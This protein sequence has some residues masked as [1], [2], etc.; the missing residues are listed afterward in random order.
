LL[1]PAVM[2]LDVTMLTAASALAQGVGLAPNLAIW[3]APVWL[4]VFLVHG[5]YDRRTVFAG[6]REYAGVL[7]GCAIA[8]LLLLV[9]VYVDPIVSRAP[10]VATWLLTSLLVSAE[11]FAVRRAVRLLRRRGHLM[12][13]TLI[14]G[15]NEEAIALAEQIVS[16]PGCGS[17]VVGFVDPGV[18]KGTRLVANLEVMGEFRQLDTLI[19]TC[20]V[21]D[22]IVATSAVSRDLLLD[23]YWSYGQDASVDLYLSS[24]VFEILTTPAKIQEINNVPLMTLQRARITELDALLK[25][26]VDY[27]LAATALVI[28][29][30]VLLV[31]A[32]L[33]RLDSPGPVLHRRQVLGVAGKPFYAFKFRTMVADADSVLARDRALRVA[34]ESGHKL[35]RDPRVT[36]VGRILRRTSVDELP[37]LLNVLRGEMSIVGPRMIAPEEAARYGRWQRNLT[38]VKPGITGPWQVAGRSDLSY[39]DRVT[40]NMQYIRNYTFW[41]DLGIL[42]RTVVVVLKGK[43]AY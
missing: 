35:K 12:R 15:A 6:V 41:L 29:S 32:L 13:N 31:I 1:A 33:I 22:I 39:E 17:R 30:P 27:V 40:L 11:R 2:V 28:L 43:G 8:T 21:R 3:I 7:A 37:Q 4:G 26:V 20:G 36:P 23:I 25:T 9:F 19:R 24:C 14:V 16:D 18:P 10:L 5:L 42:L 38:T 34:F